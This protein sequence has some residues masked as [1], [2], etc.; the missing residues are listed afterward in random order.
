[1]GDIA[2]MILE[3]DLCEYCGA[4]V[5]VVNGKIID[6]GCHDDDDDSNHIEYCCECPDFPP[7]KMSYRCLT[8]NKSVGRLRR[9]CP[10]MKKK[11]G[12]PE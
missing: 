11:L 1:M 9:I 5:G 6:C 10:T 12:I 8:I 4:Y 3:G 7:G 2:D